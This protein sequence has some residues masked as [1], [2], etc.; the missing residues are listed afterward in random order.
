MTWSQRTCVAPWHEFT[1]GL[2]TVRAYLTL[3]GKQH[4]KPEKERWLLD[5]A[6]TYCEVIRD[7]DKQ[8]AAS[9]PRSAG[10]RAFARYLAAHPGLA[11]VITLQADARA[12]HDALAELR[13]C[14]RIK[15]LRVTVQA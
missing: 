15:G 10:L 11:G 1:D 4:H 13:Y 14:V 7:L 3:V 12:V 5:A 6:L 2:R 9:E 8:L